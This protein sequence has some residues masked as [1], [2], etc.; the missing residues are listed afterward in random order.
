MMESLKKQ[1]ENF[2]PG[3]SIKLRP[4]WLLELKDY[5]K[6]EYDIVKVMGFEIKAKESWYM[7][8]ESV[9]YFSTHEEEGDRLSEKTSELILVTEAKRDNRI[10]KTKKEAQ[11]A[12]LG[13]LESDL[14]SYKKYSEDY[15]KKVQ[16]LEQV[17]LKV[18]K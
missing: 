4:F 14:R 12:L 8:K 10:F 11:K 7:A 18:K 5:D 13:K 16:N 3:N 2:A 6:S 9:M 1:L 17:L 15:T